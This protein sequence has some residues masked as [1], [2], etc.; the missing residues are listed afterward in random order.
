MQFSDYT[1]GDEKN[2][3][4]SRIAALGGASSNGIV[5]TIAIAFLEKGRCHQ[6]YQVQQFLYLILQLLS[7][8]PEA[9][10][11]DRLCAF[12]MRVFSEKIN[13]PRLLMG[14]VVICVSEEYNRKV[15]S[16]FQRF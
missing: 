7:L 11:A 16:E 8:R 14:F 9:R 5:Q 4:L 10:I 13:V 2:W 6:S 15:V 1:C 12:N 3:G